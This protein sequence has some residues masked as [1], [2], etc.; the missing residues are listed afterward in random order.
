MF[1]LVALIRSMLFILDIICFWASQE[2]CWVYSIPFLIHLLTTL[3]LAKTWQACHWGLRVMESSTFVLYCSLASV[4]S[5]IL[6]GKV[7]AWLRLPCRR[8]GADDRKLGCQL[9]H[10]R[11][12]GFVSIQSLHTVGFQGQSMCNIPPGQTSDFASACRR[13][14]YLSFACTQSSL[15]VTLGG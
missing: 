13:K 4:W 2:V 15:T 3:E 5:G 8:C 1:H 12:N 14:L 7:H 6:S 9:V 11:G 10:R